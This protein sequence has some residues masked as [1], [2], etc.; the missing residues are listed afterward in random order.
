MAG[1]LR[2]KR[3]RG[4]IWYCGPF[5]AARSWLVALEMNSRVGWILIV[6]G[7]ALGAWLDPWSFGAGV[8]DDSGADAYPRLRYAHVAVVRMAFLQLALGQL[9]TWDVF[10]R[11]IARWVGGLSLS[12]V[13]LYTL[14]F[15]GLAI[16]S[17]GGWLVPCGSLLLLVGL[18]LLARESLLR[19]GN[20]QLSAILLVVCCGLL[21]DLAMGL[22]LVSP[23]T[24]RPA[25]LGADNELRLRMLRLA[26]VAVIALA[27]LALVYHA[28][29]RDSTSR[30]VR[31]GQWGITS[32]A[33]A[34]PL[35]L[36]AGAFTTP[37]WKYL[38]AVPAWCVVGA[39]AVAIRLAAQQGQRL[40]LWGWG[41]I[42]GS[43][44]FGLLMGMYAFDGPLPAPE[45]VE[46]Y[47]GFVRRLTRL[48]HAYAIVLGMLALFVAGQQGGCYARGLRPKLL[49]LASLVTV[50]TVVVVAVGG[51]PVGA[52]SVG[53]ALV[54]LATVFC[55]SPQFRGGVA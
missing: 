36:T 12:G 28:S 53:P 16:G 2:Y 41:L 26:Q 30:V 24:F 10:R 21:L 33:L 39:V 8:A 11:S 52:L 51:L 17:I 13:V 35:V 48:G 45:F 27:T 22:F 6:M 5:N 23:D 1:N 47:D 54:A 46:S 44:L 15:F 14:G 43:L 40:T 18:G 37:A 4:A 9:L 38:L 32:G 19:G 49:V 29:T 34:M 55:V 50:L 7:F 25:Y 31:W 3:N 42:A 20:R